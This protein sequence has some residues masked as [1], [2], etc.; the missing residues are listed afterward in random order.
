MLTGFLTIIENGT[1]S[2]R[3]HRHIT[4]Y[5]QHYVQRSRGWCYYFKKIKNEVGERGE[6]EEYSTSNHNL[7]F[8]WSYLKHR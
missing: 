5:S 2:I 7:R 3:F 1:F 6:V 8:K 4:W